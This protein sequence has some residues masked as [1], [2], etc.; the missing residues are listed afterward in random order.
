[1]A[2]MQSLEEEALLSGTVAGQQSSGALGGGRGGTGGGEDAEGPQTDGDETDDYSDKAAQAALKRKYRHL[3]R[4]LG[5]DAMLFADEIFEIRP[6]EGEIWARSE[7]E[8]TVFFRP[9]TT[10]EYSSHAFLDC[11]GREERLPLRLGGSGIGPKVVLSFDVLDMGDVFI[12][13]R[14]VHEVTLLNRGDIAADWTLQAPQTPFARKFRF[15]PM[16]GTLDV[17]DSVTV[18]MEFESDILG[19]FAELFRFVLRGN[20]EPVPCQFKGHVVS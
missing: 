8:V 15:G 20:E 6:L 18:T 1:M 11:I 3:R 17:K 19:E 7:I 10:T 12:N 14:H 16:K 4:A 5:K 13:S 2:R 9:R